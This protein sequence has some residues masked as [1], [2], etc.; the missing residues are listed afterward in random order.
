[1][2]AVVLSELNRA[3]ETRTMN[4]VVHSRR[5]LLA[6]AA[7]SLI[8]KVATADIYDDYINSAS[9]QPFVA[10]LARKGIPGHAFVGIGVRLEA[11]LIVYERFFGYYPAANG[12][13]SEVK[14]IFGKASGALDYKWKDTAWDEAYVVQVDD[15]R[16]ASAIAVAD[17]WKGADP[18][19]NLFASGGKNCSTFAS[20]VAAAVGLKVPSGAGSMLPATYI[21]KLKKANGAP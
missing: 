2:P 9:K 13:A 4:D 15:A 3:A 7:I 1:M 21:E 20:E 11:G 19:Y 17:K 6:L 8:P 14:L 5:Q 16:K 18:K 12:A 10:F